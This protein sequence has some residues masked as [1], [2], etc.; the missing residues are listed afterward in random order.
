MSHRKQ[1]DTGGRLSGFRDPEV[2]Q[3][4]ECAE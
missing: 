4:E 1:G 2:N 3:P